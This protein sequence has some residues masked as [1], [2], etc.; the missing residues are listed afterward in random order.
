VRSSHSAASGP[1]DAG[2]QFLEDVL[3]GEFA[4]AVESEPS[5]PVFIVDPKTQRPY[6]ALDQMQ[7]GF[8]PLE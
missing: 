5:C 8:L 4:S 7:D 6:D 2:F 1:P 3:F